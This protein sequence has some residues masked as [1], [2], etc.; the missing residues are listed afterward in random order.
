M[1]RNVEKFKVFLGLR[2]VCEVVEMFRWLQCLNTQRNA[3]DIL[4][5]SLKDIGGFVFDPKNVE[6]FLIFQVWAILVIV[7]ETVS[8]LDGPKCS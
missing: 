3:V 1:S 8:K 2:K 4:M 7:F 6:N 5:I